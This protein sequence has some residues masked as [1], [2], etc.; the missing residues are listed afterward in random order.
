[1]SCHCC[2]QKCHLLGELEQ[3]I[4][5]VIWSSD[6]PLKP[7]EVQKL[8]KGDYAYTTI[9]TVL[10]RLSSKKILKRV[11]NGNSYSYSSPSTK[12]EFACTCL[13]DLFSRLITTYG[14]SAINSFQ[15]VVKKLK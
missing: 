9:M 11:K 3:K 12:D 2:Q 1:M 10:S 5:E 8:L 14:Q 6:Q 13:E 15:K 7:S 4:M